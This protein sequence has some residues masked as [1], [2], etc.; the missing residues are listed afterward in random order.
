M[1]DQ[2]DLP[3]RKGRG[4]KRPPKLVC[5]IQSIDI[6]CE[7]DPE[8]IRRAIAGAMDQIFGPLHAALEQ[9][10]GVPDWVRTCRECG[11][12]EDNACVDSQGRPCHWV[13]EDLCSACAE[14]GP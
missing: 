13:A 5:R 14:G 9:A 12:T 10:V 3:R 2:P 6:E 1:P 8:E 11:C 4:R 7:G